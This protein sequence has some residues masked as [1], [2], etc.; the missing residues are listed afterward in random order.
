V[1]VAALLAELPG[2]AEIRRKAVEVLARPEYRNGSPEEENATQQV[3]L[4]ALRA[5]RDAYNWIV[6]LTESVPAYVRYPVAAA[7]VVV[8]ILVFVHIIYTLRQAT[9]LPAQGSRLRERQ[10]RRQSPDELVTLARQE[11]EQGRIVEAARL[12]LRAGLR[13]LEQA[14]KRPHRPGMTN[15]ELLLRY[16]SS[17]VFEPLR[18]LVS[19]IDRKWYGDEPAVSEDYRS[20]LDAEQRLQAVLAARASRA[21]AANAPRVKAP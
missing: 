5:V 18:T 3:L 13:R 14:E 16:R 12:L 15:R 11:F 21:A 9:Q 8:L 7:L 2:P 17:P 20:C 1:I 6:G 10:G 19:T 4:S